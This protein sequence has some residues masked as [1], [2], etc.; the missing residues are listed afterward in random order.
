MAFADRSEAGRRLAASLTEFAGQDVVVLGLPRGGVVV[1]AEV[2]AAIG[3]P[4]D[5]IVVRKLGFPAQPE[6]AMGA[7]GEGD[8]KVVNAEGALLAKEDPEGAAAVERYEREELARR[9]HRFRGDRAQ[10]PLQGKTV[11]IVDDGIATGATIRVACEVA[12]AQGAARI[13]VAAPIAPA[14]VVVDLA[15]VA[16]QVVCPHTPGH[17]HAIGQWYDDFSPTPDDQV[18]ELLQRG[19]E[20]TSGAPKGATGGAAQAADLGTALLE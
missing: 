18:V 20:N 9:A 6:L 1:A 4:L 2:A 13:V 8:A 3:A 14:S 12:R 7:I 17:F 19:L 16:D 5:V 15:S 10:V 11:I